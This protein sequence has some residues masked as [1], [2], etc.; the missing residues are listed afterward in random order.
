[1]FYQ[2]LAKCMTFLAFFKVHYLYLRQ[3]ILEQILQW[4]LRGLQTDCLPVLR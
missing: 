4:L 2:D 1:M 3:W